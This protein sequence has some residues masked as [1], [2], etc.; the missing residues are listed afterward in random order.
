MLRPA[1][2]ITLIAVMLYYCY[3][4]IRKTQ[5]V[6][7]FKGLLILV[8]C[9]FIAKV[10]HLYTV[11][12]V[13]SKLL[14]V[15]VIAFLVVFQPEMRY[16]LERLGQGRL[17]F[18]APREE[19]MVEILVRTVF[20][21]AEKRIGALI[22]I[23]NH[24]NLKNYMTAGVIL[25]SL[26]SFEL[27]HTIFM[28]HTPLHDGGVIIRGN[29]VAA[30]SCLFPLS[31]RRDLSRSLGTR[32]R[33]AVGLSEETDALTIVVSEETGTVSIARDGSISRNI[34]RSSLSRVLTNLLLTDPAQKPLLD[35]GQK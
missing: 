12:W 2:E 24:V 1:V 25:D 22:V 35:L 21:L 18:N 34:D 11:D 20:A 28:P 26:V 4:L 14:T 33:A 10:F 31:Q 13:L 16:F 9:F 7:V 19:S 17:S 6:R 29:R 3:L 5:A 30:A 23:E 8:F 27:L 32:H 15:A